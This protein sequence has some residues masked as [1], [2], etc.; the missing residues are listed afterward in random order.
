MLSGAGYRP[1]YG[2]GLS[3][4]RV[5]LPLSKH[6]RA[7][8]SFLLS[9]KVGRPWAVESFRRCLRAYYRSIFCMERREWNTILSGA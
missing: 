9:T 5:G 8:D 7:R 3:E 2:L 6:Y 1:R 4:H